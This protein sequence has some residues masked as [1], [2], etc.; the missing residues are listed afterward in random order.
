MVSPQD[1]MEWVAHITQVSSEFTGYN[2]IDRH[3]RLIDGTPEP[4]QACDR[5]FI[6][7]IRHTVESLDGK[8][9]SAALCTASRVCVTCTTI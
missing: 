1:Q 6:P 8:R 3:Y 9:L 7:M 5:V 4:E 2:N